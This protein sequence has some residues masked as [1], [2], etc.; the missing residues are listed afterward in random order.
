MALS[1][2]NYPKGSGPGRMTE[3]CTFQQTD[4]PDESKGAEPEQSLSGPTSKDNK[5]T[6]LLSDFTYDG[7]S[8]IPHYG[9]PTEHLLTVD[10]I[11]LLGS[12][13]S[14]VAGWYIISHLTVPQSDHL[15]YISLMDQYLQDIFDTMKPVFHHSGTSLE[16]PEVLVSIWGWESEKDA[17]E[18]MVVS[19]KLDPEKNLPHSL[20]SFEVFLLR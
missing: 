4:V 10:H 17:Q 12:P 16:N 18:Y 1:Q 14:S 20:H 8:N 13:T 9:P 7:S 3:I 15:E 19:L 11:L 5:I 2:L 6:A